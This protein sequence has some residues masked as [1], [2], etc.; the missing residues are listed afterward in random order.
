MLPP[1]SVILEWIPSHTGIEGNEKADNL[2]KKALEL[3]TINP[4][5]LSLTESNR[6]ITEHYRQLWQQEWSSNPRTSQLQKPTLGPPKY[7]NLA[8]RDS[9][10]IARLSL[11][12]NQT[13]TWTLLPANVPPCLQL[14]LHTSHPHTCY[15]KLHPVLHPE[16]PTHSHLPSPT[17]APV[18]IYHTIRH[19]P[20]CGAPPLPPYHRPE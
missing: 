16:S 15:P 20:R 5:P 13:V 12:S 14:L 4:I 10:P 19:I 18:N 17:K 6:L 2:A 7:S 8:R 9:V 3:P 11:G 1:N